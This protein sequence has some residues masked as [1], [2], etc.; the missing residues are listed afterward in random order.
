MDIRFM[1]S[2][3]Q[4][5]E[6]RFAIEMGKAIRYLS[7]YPGVRRVWLFGSIAKGRKPDWRSDL[8]FAVE[9]LPYEDYL[10]ACG[11]LEGLIA[12]PVD[13]VRIEEAN[14]FLKSQI[15]ETGKIVYET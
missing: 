15:L 2:S 1:S 3:P 5:Q 10:R 4:E 13:L 9:G 6:Q 7:G 14:D 11:E 12:I 8:D